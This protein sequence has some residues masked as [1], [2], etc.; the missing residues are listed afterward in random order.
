[1]GTLSLRILTIATAIFV[2]PTAV[3]ATETY[4]RV[5]KS[6]VPVGIFG[7]GQIDPITCTTD[8]NAVLQPNVSRSPQHGTLETRAVKM[9][10]NSI[11]GPHICNGKPYEGL[12]IFYTSA[13]GYRGPDRI[14]LQTTRI[15]G[16]ME[17]TE[18][19][20]YEIDVQ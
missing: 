18:T 5:A 2:L 6:G 3:H 17:A 7:L 12:A 16:R 20:V 19:L 11:S 10:F 8:R 9:T 14:E 13:K 15:F 4:K 1:M